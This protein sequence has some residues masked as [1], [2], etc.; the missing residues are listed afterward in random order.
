MND[1]KYNFFFDDS[2]AYIEFNIPYDKSDIIEAISI[3]KETFTSVS[4]NIVAT[5]GLTGYWSAF[6]YNKN[7]S[8]YC[9]SRSL[10]DTK[11][12]IKEYLNEKF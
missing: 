12:K 8:I 4:F 1:Q 2:A 9:G 6:D 7:N 5:K 11:R 10:G 3:L